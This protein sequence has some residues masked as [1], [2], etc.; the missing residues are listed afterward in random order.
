MNE[1]E[2]RKRESQNKRAV[3]VTLFVIAALTLSAFFIGYNYGYKAGKAEERNKR[4]DY[5]LNTLGGHFGQLANPTVFEAYPYPYPITGETLNGLKYQNLTEDNVDAFLYELYHLGMYDW[6]RW[7]IG[8]ARWSDTEMCRE[9]EP[10]S[11]LLERFEKKHAA[12]SRLTNK[13][14]KKEALEE[15]LQNTHNDFEKLNHLLAW[16]GN[17]SGAIEI[18]TEG[19]AR[20]YLDQPI[21]PIEVGTDKY[22]YTEGEEIRFW[23]KNNGN[24]KQELLEPP[25][26]ILK[27][28]RVKNINETIRNGERIITI[29]P[30][31]SVEWEKIYEPAKNH[32]ITLNPREKRVWRWNQKDINNT[33]VPPGE[34]RV[35][36]SVAGWVEGTYSK[37]FIIK[38][39]QMRSEMKMEKEGISEVKKCY[40]TKLP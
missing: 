9:L 30:D 13:K 31:V 18:A 17:L 8:N 26:V 32:A 2:I 11:H 34:Y 38:K 40:A 29:N 19:H 15:L 14:E 36:F 39:T 23:L 27:K 4:I 20:Q 10:F 25:Y 35:M 22:V 33:Q 21:Y 16:A 12:I 37:P 28:L 6:Y 7:N 3:P 24:S 5:A 1:K